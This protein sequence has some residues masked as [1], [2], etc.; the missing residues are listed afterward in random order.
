[1]TEAVKRKRAALGLSATVYTPDDLEANEAGYLSKAQI[2]RLR[3][4]INARV[5]TLAGSLIFAIVA[6]II[7][8]TLAPGIS[9]L[10]FIMLA[11]FVFTGGYPIFDLYSTFHHAAEY[12]RVKSVSGPIQREIVEKGGKELEQT[13]WFHVQNTSNRY[14]YLECNSA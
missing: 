10:L 8:S 7:L 6:V 12:G 2:E 11:F 3:R 1:M 14:C 4:V 9:I 5:K 13:W